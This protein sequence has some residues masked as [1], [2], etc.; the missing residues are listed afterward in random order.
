MAQAGFIRWFIDFMTIQFFIFVVFVDRKFFEL[1]ILLLNPKQ[2]CGSD[3]VQPIKALW[4]FIVCS[5]HFGF[6]RKTFVSV[7]LSSWQNIHLVACKVP[8]YLLLILIRQVEIHDLSDLLNSCKPSSFLFCKVSWFFPSHACSIWGSVY[9]IIEVL[10]LPNIWNSFN[11]S[12]Q[13]S[14]SEKIK[15]PIQEHNQ[16]EES[17]EWNSNTC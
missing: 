17:N 15:S 5:C 1:G 10:S 7:F 11:I 3:A 16:K 12:V 9:R 6:V 2:T 14:T 4:N 8:F 13:E